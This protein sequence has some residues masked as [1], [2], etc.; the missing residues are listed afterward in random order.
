MSEEVTQEHHASLKNSVLWVVAV[1]VIVGLGG[2]AS[3]E[4]WVIGQ[5]SNQVA[6]LTGD[7]AAL[8]EEKASLETNAAEISAAVEEIA[9]RIQDV[10]Q[11]NVVI[12]QLVAQTA[13]GTA[14]EKIL[15]DIASV[16][17]QL[18]HD[19][20][21]I[22][23]LTAKMQDAGIR[24]GSLE[25]V[26]KSLRSD[27]AGNEER[28]EN[29]RSIVEQK[30]EVIRTTETALSETQN[31]LQITQNSLDMT[32]QELTDTQNTLTEMKNTAYYVIGSK[33][34]LK[35]L[36]VISESGWFVFNKD[37]DLVANIDESAFNKIDM[38]EQTR[39][40]IERDPND[41]KILPVRPENSYMLEETGEDSCVLT[42]TDTDQFWKIRYL[43]IMV[44][45]RD[46][47][48]AVAAVVQ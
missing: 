31:E 33:N 15:D 39:F 12:S 18:Q 28:I 8:E 44:D 34:E 4:Y 21:Q 37:V 35:D 10:R 47:S 29:L 40:A 16:E 43:A 6:V 30:D 9:A 46:Y 11:H 38:T 3:Y 24:I 45:G 42:V 32:V 48:T 20:Q 14:K 5:K 22:D 17:S 27:I 13:E 23:E 41:L 36:N 1:L 25:A 26:I 19:K 2:Y 7:N